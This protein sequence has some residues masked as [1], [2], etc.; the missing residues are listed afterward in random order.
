MCSDARRDETFSCGCDDGFSRFSQQHTAMAAASSPSLAEP[1]SQLVAQIPR[2]SL[3][4]KQ[5]GVPDLTDPT[6]LTHSVPPSADEMMTGWCHLPSK[7]TEPR[8]P[9]GRSQP[10]PHASG[11]SSPA[12]TAPTRRADVCP[13][14]PCTR[15]CCCRPRAVQNAGAKGEPPTGSPGEGKERDATP[16]RFR[17]HQQ[18]SWQL[19]SHRSGRQQVSQRH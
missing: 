11:R 17:N 13:A 3:T 4:S 1:P 6:T 14:L 7:S 18:P 10:L 5:V 8:P 2:V 15:P 16:R 19:A 9:T 12:R